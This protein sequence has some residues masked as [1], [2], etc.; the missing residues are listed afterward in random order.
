MNWRRFLHRDAAD[1]EQH[2]E[3]EFHV[4]LTA[5]EY[6][7]RGMDP[8]AARAAARRKL[9][10]ATLIREE[11]YRMNTLTV[12]ESALR[13]VRHALRMIRTKPG[14][15]IAALL[16]LALGI[17]ANTAIFSVVNGVLI[18]PLSYPE[19]D[20]LV[21]VFNSAVLQGQVIDNMSLSPGMYG[22]FKTGAQTFKEF[23]VWTAG[24]AT[25]T[26]TG[27][28]EQIATVT[29]TQGVLP[30][31]GV[32]PY[33]GR[34]FS[35]EDDTRGSQ[36]TVILC[37]GYWQR[38][39]GGDRQVIGRTVL[40]DFVPREVIGIMPESFRFVNL[41]PDVL[42]PQRFPSSQLRPDVFNHS[43]IARLKPGVS[44]DMANQ[45]V[46]RVLKSWGDTDRVRRWVEQL[47]ITPDLRPLKQDVVGDVSTVLGVL[48]G[49][50][51]LVLLLVCANVANL[52]LVRAQ[53][54]RQEFAVRAALGAGWGRIARELLVES[55]TLGVLGGTLGL[56][57][58]YGGL[59]LLVALAPAMLPRLGE[60]S[61]DA[62]SLAFALAC[63]LGSSLLFGLIAVLKCGRPGEM[64]STRGATQGTEQLRAQQALVVTQVAL[65]LVLLVASGLMIRS[66]LALHTVRPGFT[67]PGWIQ[68]VRISI[69]EAQTPDPERVSRMQADIVVRLATIPGVA[70]AAFATALPMELEFRNGIV[71][72]VE[73]KTPVDQIP[74]NRTTK[75]VS[76]GLFASLGTRL[77]AGRDFTWNDVFNQRRVAVVSE[78]MARE[79]WGEPGNA[80]ARRIRIGRDGPWTEVVGV[81]ENVYDDGVHRQAPPTVYLRAGVEAPARAEG[82]ATVRRGITLAIR[83]TRAG[84]E[85]FVRE[86]TAAIHGVNPS[87]PLARVQTLNVVYKRSMARTSFA[88]VLLG[89]A[90]AMALT[91]AIIGVYAVLAYAVAQRRKE[92][93]IRVALGAQPGMVRM[94][95]VR[96]GL[97]LTLA[98]GAIGL[99]AAAGL[100]SWISS[101]LYGITPLDPSTY[102]VSAAILLAA[103]LAASYIPARGAA[104]ADPMETLRSD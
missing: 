16:S 68:T 61:I 26:G 88:L 28:P 22:A 50:L 56:V 23:G 27:D 103:A 32:A 67:Q 90:G 79:N 2:G 38:K 94:L 70:A 14:F 39:F 35:R 76:P 99:A 24:A 4:D 31:L 74:P 1:A 72:A 83:S 89:T 37:H 47:R 75:Y 102:A 62:T 100:S 87:L 45:D 96:Q 34:W 71:V 92:V 81:A 8:A 52:V 40:I 5:E 101:L 53:A 15:S 54:R 84:T 19:P 57:L 30:A 7:E 18:R 10:N 85:D 59:R 64:Q 93:S 97:R 104:L 78:N 17:G 6:V 95:F 60:T 29:M 55:I 63:S 20:A 33:S 51:A 44:L 12:A 58:A 9:G 43:G 3:L 36:E 48:M 21:G 66:F 46:A 69:P 80:L 91:L 25:V 73:G 42:L 11:V 13:D 49:S 77:I 65:A 41:A 98:G 86:I 82:T